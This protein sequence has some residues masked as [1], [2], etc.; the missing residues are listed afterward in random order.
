MARKTQL[1]RMMQSNRRLNQGFPT[2]PIASLLTG[3]V[4]AKMQR[5]ESL[6]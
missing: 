2:I 1:A 4:R 5:E 3:L 6:A